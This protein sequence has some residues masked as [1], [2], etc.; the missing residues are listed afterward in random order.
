MG[1]LFTPKELL[2]L[3]RQNPHFILEGKSAHYRRKSSYDNLHI[4]KM[5]NPDLEDGMP[6]LKPYQ[7]PLDFICCSYAKRNNFRDCNVAVHFFCDDYVF[8]HAVWKKLEFTTYSL[9]D[10]NVLFAPDY[11]LHVDVPDAVNINNVYKSRLIGSYWQYFGYDVIPVASWGSA[12]SFDYC[13]KG[14]PYDSVIAVCGV[15]IY[16]DENVFE[17]WKSALLRIEEERHPICFIVYGPE[18]LV[19]GLKTPMRFIQD[20]VSMKFKGLV[21][22]KTKYNG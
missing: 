10:F 5:L 16:H 19:S 1:E 9:I 15:G 18:V 7:K 6:K 2:K 3:D 4:L 13:F 12:Q 17:L 20:H 14:L 22:N 21:I 8:D 11:S